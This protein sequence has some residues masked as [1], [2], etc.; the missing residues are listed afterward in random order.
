MLSEVVIVAGSCDLFLTLGLKIVM[1]NKSYSF[2]RV[3][4]MACCGCFGFAFARKPKRLVKKHIGNHVSQD[5]LLN[6]E[7]DDKDNCSHNGD[8]SDYG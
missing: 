1:F 2:A 3:T 6:V 8:S 5:F 7:L 4:Q